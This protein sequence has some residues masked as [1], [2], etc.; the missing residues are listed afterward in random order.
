MARQVKNEALQLLAIHN[1]LPGANCSAPERHHSALAIRP[2]LQIF[3]WCQNFIVHT[4]GERRLQG[5]N[6]EQT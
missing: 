2:D 1:L 6:S 3:A 4:A 5:W